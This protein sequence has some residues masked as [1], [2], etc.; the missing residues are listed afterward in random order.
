MARFLSFPDMTCIYCY[1]RFNKIKQTHRTMFEKKFTD[2]LAAS[3]CSRY[4]K[5]LSNG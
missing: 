2:A 1:T 4:I 5:G 3:A